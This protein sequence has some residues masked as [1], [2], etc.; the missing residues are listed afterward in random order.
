MQTR[1]KRPNEKRLYDFDFAAQPE[2][3][4]GANITDADPL[5]VVGTGL[6]VGDPTISGSKV[7]YP[8]TGGTDGT[9]YLLTCKITL[10]TVIS[11]GPTVYATLEDSGQLEVFV[12]DEP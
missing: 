3:V 2:I 11:T 10:D 8:I 6:T 12:E 4:A 7:F 1:Q 9:K 5:V